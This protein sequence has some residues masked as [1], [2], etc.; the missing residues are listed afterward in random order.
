MSLSFTLRVAFGVVQRCMVSMTQ[1][2]INDFV[3]MSNIEA[4]KVA[5]WAQERIT[6]QIIQVLRSYMI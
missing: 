1:E 4:L 3:Y 6:R 5:Y 2:M